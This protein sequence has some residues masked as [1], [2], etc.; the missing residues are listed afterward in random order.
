MLMVIVMLNHMCDYDPFLDFF[1]FVFNVCVSVVV[2]VWC[3]S[4]RYDEEK[5]H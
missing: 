3:F 1:F 5:N 2:C 4:K